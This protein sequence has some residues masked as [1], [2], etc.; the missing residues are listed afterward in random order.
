MYI[1]LGIKY[2]QKGHVNQVKSFLFLC[3]SFLCVLRNF[4]WEKIGRR[5][6]YRFKCKKK[7]FNVSVNIL[8]Q[9]AS[10]RLNDMRTFVYCM[11]SSVTNIIISFVIFILNGRLKEWILCEKYDNKWKMWLSLRCLKERK[12][13]HHYYINAV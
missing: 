1:Y 12:T 6:R 8:F 13:N 9:S 7:D 3:L 10:C 11:C 4:L 5:C 2:K